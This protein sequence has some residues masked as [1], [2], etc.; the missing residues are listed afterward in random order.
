MIVT[1]L[2]FLIFVGC[3][4]IGLFLVVVPRPR[5]AKLVGAALLASF[6]CGVW[7]ASYGL[8]RGLEPEPIGMQLA[9][10]LSLTFLIAAVALLISAAVR[11]WRRRS[12]DPD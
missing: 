7:W 2:L 8:D 4:L 11:R 12:P 1:G 5:M 6:A 3:P 10:G 9:A